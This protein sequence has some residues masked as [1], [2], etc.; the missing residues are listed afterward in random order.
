MIVGDYDNFS[1]NFDKYEHVWT[2]LDMFGQD[3]CQEK[4]FQVVVV[5]TF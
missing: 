4:Y 5:G 3:L 2:I 1:P